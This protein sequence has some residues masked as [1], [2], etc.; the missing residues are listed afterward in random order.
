L[1]KVETHA[2]NEQIDLDTKDG[3]DR[4]KLFE[5]H[6]QHVACSS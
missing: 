4:T 5:L 6:C 2:D 3:V 1:G